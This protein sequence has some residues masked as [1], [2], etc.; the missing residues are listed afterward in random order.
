M[1]N[2]NALKTSGNRCGH[3][4][5]SPRLE[6]LV[7]IKKGKGGLPRILSLAAEKSKSW[8]Y[9]PNKCPKLNSRSNRKTRSER[10]EAIIIIIETL[11]KR[12]DLASMRIGLPAQNG[13]FLDID[14]KTIVKESGLGQRRCERAIS[15]L[16]RAGFL[17]VS[18]KHIK[19]APGKYI[20]LRAVRIITHDFFAWLGLDKILRAERTKALGRKMQQAAKAVSNV[21][22]QALPIKKQPRAPDKKTIELK[23]AWSKAL[24]SLILQGIDMN[25]AHKQVNQQF[26]LPPWWSPSQDLPKNR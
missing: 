24:S 1:I 26:G 25:N 7:P 10:R 13:C 14:I 22:T 9:E 5:K 3:N 16:K 23:V 19:Q 12:L 2:Q 18:Q 8:Y 15:H 20:A 21:V 11:L 17:K 6:P 4:L